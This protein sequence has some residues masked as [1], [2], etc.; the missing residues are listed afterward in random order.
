MTLST[1]CVT[2]ECGR[3]RQYSNGMC[4]ACWKRDRRQRDAAIREHDAAVSRDWKARNKAHVHAYDERYDAEHR[5]TCPNCGGACGLSSG[6]KDHAPSLCQRCLDERAE[7][8]RVV[9]V[10]MWREGASLKE[11]AARLGSTSGAVQVQMVR[12]RAD[13]YDLP[14]RYAV[15]G[16]KRVAA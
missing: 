1:T 14:Y 11:I 7:K 3:I 4:G 5:A 6:K 2:P 9:I 10:E 12:M 8:R 13:G 15:R 16:G